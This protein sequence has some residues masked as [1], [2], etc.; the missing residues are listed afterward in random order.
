MFVVCIL[1]RSLLQPLS[2]ERNMVGASQHYCD[3][4][5]PVVAKNILSEKRFKKAREQCVDRFLQ[6]SCLDTEDVQSTMDKVGIS[7]QSYTQLFKVIQGKLKQS[8]VKG[9]LLPKPSYV[10]QARHSINSRVMEVLG[11]PFHITDT[12]PGKKKE[13]K[14]NSF[15]NIFFDLRTLQRAMIKFYELKHE[16]VNGV[17]IFVLKLD[18]SELLK[19]RKLERVS[20]TLMNRALQER[21]GDQGKKDPGHF[22]VQSEQHIWWLGAFEVDFEDFNILNWVFQRTCIPEVIRAQQVGE[23]LDVEGFG[24]YKVQ[25]H[26]AGD[27]K[28]LKC[29]YNVSKGANA[30]SPCI[31]CMG[32]AKECKPSNW[33]KA[34]DRHTK[35]NNFQPVL[36][37]PLSHVHICTLHALCR[38]VE[39]LVYLYI[40]FAWKLQPLSAR[41]DAIRSIEK[42][43]SEIGLHGGN[44][45]IETDPQKSSSGN[46]V[47]KKPSI[48]GVKARRFLGFHGKLGK[49]NLK[50]GTSNII[51]NQWKALHNAVKDHGDDGRARNR[52]AGVWQALDA[53]FSYCDKNHWSENDMGAFKKELN[54][55]KNCMRDAWTYNNF[56]HYMVRNQLVQNLVFKAPR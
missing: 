12:Y 52:K 4:I 44:V 56:T 23:E 18:E 1:G 25:W 53:V 35:D 38:I 36:D 33:N 31:Y 46:N 2:A 24:R 16:E 54:N 7:R 22:S 15:N 17:A 21:E 29:M 14:F 49:I 50:K 6:S 11:E 43:L 20:I 5:P 48:G 41:E 34:P 27:L 45:V 39:K 30:K 19:G 10:Q 40:G 51:Y 47:A 9:S 3:V 32:S 26:M 28:T 37:I 42:V 55:F 13:L 8:K